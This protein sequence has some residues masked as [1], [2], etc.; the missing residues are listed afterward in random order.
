MQPVPKLWTAALLVTSGL[1]GCA[2]GPEELQVPT[3]LTD[4]LPIALEHNG[5]AVAPGGVTDASLAARKGAARFVPELFARFDRDRAM[6]IAAFV[7]KEYRE[8]A[9]D[10]YERVVDRLVA[11]LY[12]A[13]FGAEAGYG[14][15]LRKSSLPD[16]S[17]TPL[18]AVI[19]FVRVDARGA[20]IQNL[21]V[22]SVDGTAAAARVIQ[23]ANAPG[24]ELVGAIA[25]G[26]DALTTPGM[27]LLTDQPIRSVELDALARGA[28]AVISTYL[29]SY[30]VDPT[31]RERHLEA[32]FHGDVR[33]GTELPSF[34]VSPKVGDAIRNTARVGG[35]V[36]LVAS[37]RFAVRPL[38]TVVATIAGAERP[39][40]AVHL[41]SH[42]D[43][44]GANDN[45]SGVGAMVEG[46]LLLKRLIDQRLLPRPRRTLAFVFGQVARAGG[47]AIKAAPGPV[48]AAIVADMLGASA[49]ETGAVCLLERGWDPAAIA[50]L[51]PDRHTALG[52]GNV[53][54]GD[55]FGTGLSIVMRQA[56]IDV[57]AFEA[58]RG[59]VR[60]PWLTREH[61]WEGGRDQDAYLAQGI[62]ACRLWH[63]TDF[64]HATSLDRMAMVDPD[65]LRRTAVA[66]MAGALTVAD[67]QPS[68]LARHLASL[69]LERQ[70]RLDAVVSADAG[71]AA[72][73]AWKTWFDQARFWLQSVCLGEPLPAVERAAQ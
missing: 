26:I 47:A 19:E 59:G 31:G 17:W 40:E 37:A 22:V 52:P 10:G 2:G 61:P 20:P 13:G 49:A 4:N 11:D 54:E 63:F 58:S 71:D 38:R 69:N 6:G 23:P 42:I 25:D 14:L 65:E 36:R 53:A 66:A 29:P 8:P 68:D 62:A 43:G 50:P 32:I 24:C 46:A 33:P 51:P 60:A 55:L 21:N 9:S 35:H 16:P 57:A 70:M 15:D 7:D 73:E 1:F 27:V 12:A 67:G 48:V 41:L 5:P 18:S 3:D 30:C 45:A 28:A 34:Y 39:D 72:I 44:A 64:A 56:L